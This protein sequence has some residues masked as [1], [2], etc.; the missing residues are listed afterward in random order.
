LSRDVDL[1]FGQPL[2]KAELDLLLGAAEGETARDTAERRVV[3]RF[4][5]MAQWKRMHGK[6]GSKTQAH[7]VAI[8]YHTGLLKPRSVA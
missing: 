6:L 5:V 8:A 7:A 3:S 2:T 4:T 1:Y